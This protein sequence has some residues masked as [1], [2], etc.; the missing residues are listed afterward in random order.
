MGII[1]FLVDTSASM[2]QRTYSGVTLLDIAKGAVE[3]FVKVNVTQLEFYLGC[4]IVKFCP[5][6]LCRPF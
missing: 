3:T 4:R 2:N 5:F 1:V 6:N